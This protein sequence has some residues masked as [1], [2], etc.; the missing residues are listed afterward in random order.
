MESLQ[1][2]V[3]GKNQEILDTLKRI[4]ENNE[5]W[6]AEIKSD[7]N[8][9]YDYIKE[10]QVNIVLLSSGL[11]EKFENEVKTFCRNLNKDVKV[12][13]HYGG[14]SGLLKNEVYSLFPNLQP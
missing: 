14:G 9:C 12:I 6:K 3:I 1:F 10:N 13:D 7:E 5:G 8:V 11:E 4:I 2:L